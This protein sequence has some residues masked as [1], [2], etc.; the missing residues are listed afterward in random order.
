MLVISQSYCPVRASSA[1]V[2]S[3]RPQ[4]AED[5]QHQSRI[6]ERHAKASSKHKRGCRIVV[7]VVVVVAVVVV[8]F[9]DSISS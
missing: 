8:V 3:S 7:V 6:K 1:G 2:G 4:S 9:K 5:R